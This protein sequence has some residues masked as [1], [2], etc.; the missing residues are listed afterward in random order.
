MIRLQN[1]YKR[2]ASGRE[3]LSNLSLHISPGEMVFL[4]GHSGAGKSTLLKLIALIE[5]PTRGQMIIR[6]QNV[7]RMSHKK[8]PQYRRAIG[9]VFQDYA[10]FPHLPV[11]GDIGF[12]LKDLAPG[13]KNRRIEELLDLVGM[14]E[15]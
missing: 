4:T 14:S 11:S 12:G 2:Y 1:V 13:D 8:I 10:L 5:R 7:T 9:M 15:A 6:G 3:A